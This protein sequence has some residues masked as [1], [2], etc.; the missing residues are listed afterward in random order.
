MRLILLYLSLM[1]FSACDQLTGGSTGAFTPS[2][3]S[4]NIGGSDSLQIS[5]GRFLLSGIMDNGGNSG[6][7]FSVTLNLDLNQSATIVFASDR[8]LAGGLE[9]ILQRTTLGLQMNASLNG[10]SHQHLLVSAD[11][12]HDQIDLSFDIHNDHSDIHFIIWHDAGPFGDR[13]NCTF[14]G[15]CLYNSEDFALDAWLG[16]GRA[17]GANWGVKTTI[18]NRILKVTGPSTAI[19]DA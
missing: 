5:P 15:Q 4:L 2:N 8:N 7:N 13:D 3:D 1:L 16:V 6:H 18:P 19:S 10:L 14:D 17:R 12:L 9:V 11:D